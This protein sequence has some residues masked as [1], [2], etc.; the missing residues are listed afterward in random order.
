MEHPKG[1][2]QDLDFVTW[3][4]PGCAPRT[5]VTF[6]DT[7]NNTVEAIRQL[8]PKEDRSKICWFNSSM[9]MSRFCSSVTLEQPL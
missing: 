3:W 6:Y 2:F 1:S 5:Y 8:L 4:E 7:T 9:S